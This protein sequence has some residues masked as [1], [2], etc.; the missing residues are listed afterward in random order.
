MKLFA[1]F[2]VGFFANRKWM[3]VASQDTSDDL[4]CIACAR[5][6]NL[7]KTIEVPHIF[8]FKSNSKH[9]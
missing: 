1:L 3:F 5:A 9:L 7:T 6:L 8:L 4:K 2:F